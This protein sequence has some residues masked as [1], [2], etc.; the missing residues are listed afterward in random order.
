ML[1][2]DCDVFSLKKVWI[3]WKKT[4]ERCVVIPSARAQKVKHTYE[5]VQEKVANEVEKHDESHDA[6]TR[7]K[8]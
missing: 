7:E 8:R 4:N 1:W 2:Y 5:V 3:K 6:E